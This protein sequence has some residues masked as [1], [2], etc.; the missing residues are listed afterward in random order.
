VA[1]EPE[2]FELIRGLFALSDESRAALQDFLAK[3]DPRPTK[4]T[5]EGD[6]RCVLSRIAPGENGKTPLKIVS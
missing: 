3:T 1:Q 2:F 6:G 5:I 4:V